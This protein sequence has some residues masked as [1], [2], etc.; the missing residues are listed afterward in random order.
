[1]GHTAVS[2]AVMIVHHWLYDVDAINF[3]IMLMFNI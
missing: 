2:Y 3:I 1:M